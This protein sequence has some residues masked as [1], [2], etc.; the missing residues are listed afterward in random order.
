MLH[1]S[2]DEAEGALPQPAASSGEENGVARAEA[3]LFFEEHGD[4]N[5]YF[6]DEDVPDDQAMADWRDVRRMN[7]L[8]GS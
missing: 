6:D 5:A 8:L 1:A 7:R 3:L 2:G 4:E